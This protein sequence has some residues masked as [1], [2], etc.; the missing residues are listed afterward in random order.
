[1]KVAIACDRDVVSDH[2][3]RCEKYVIFETHEGKLKNTYDLENPGHQPG[4]LPK[5]LKDKG[6]E[7]LITGG[8]GPRALKIFDLC[9]IKVVASVSGRVQDII[10]KFCKGELKGEPKPCRH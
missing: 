9:G 1:M 8:I 5:F 7:V 10:D 3:G 2:F 6:V 4:F